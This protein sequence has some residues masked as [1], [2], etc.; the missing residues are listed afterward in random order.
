MNQRGLV[1]RRYSFSTLAAIALALVASCDGGDPIGP[2][3][4]AG[5]T[6]V[7]VSGTPQSGAVG[8]A[9]AQDFV[10]R[11]EDQ[12]GTPLAGVSV[13]WSVTAGGGSITP[14]T[15]LTDAQ[16][17]SQARL[18]LGA[19]AGTNTAQAL[20]AGVAPVVFTATGTA[21]GGPGPTPPVGQVVYRK[22]DAGS[23]HTC[24]ITTTELPLC[25]GFN[26]NGELGN[27][28]TAS[29]LLP[30]AVSGGLNFR[31]VSGGKFHSCAVSLAGDGYCWGSNLE[32]QLGRAGEIKSVTPVLNAKA[33]TFSAISV[34][35]AHSCGIRLDGLAYCWGS[36]TDGQLGFM[37]EHS[38]VDTAGRVRT[39]GP[40]FNQIAAGGLH[41]CGITLIGETLCWGFNDQGQLGN[42]GTITI[43]PDTTGPSSLTP[44]L[45]APVFDSVTAGYKHT[46]AL[47][48]A[49]LAY[50]WGDNAFGQLG[51]GTTTTRLAPVPVAGGTTFIALSAGFYHTCGIATGGAAYCWGRNSPNELQESVGGQIGDGTTT[52]KS[53]PAL[54]SGGLLFKSLSAGEVTTCGVTTTGTAYCW[55]DNEYGQLGTGD[56]ISAQVPV[57]VAGQP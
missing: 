28:A 15:D 2:L 13:T 16:G 41:N 3:P 43:F 57:R 37:T 6:L 9:L 31:Q 25:W 14:T 44:V 5:T 19:T 48:A 20:V 52:S 36:N 1:Y 17:L 22:I 18:T 8:T 47:D 12:S 55:G 38:S 40:R 42:G 51:D 54:V 29:S 23:Y 39:L 56:V 49:G 21:G 24:A 10:V 45:G 34:G 4:V 35:R 53:S 30:T 50:C 11:A 33:I 27:N 46:C 26:Q 32:G 7:L